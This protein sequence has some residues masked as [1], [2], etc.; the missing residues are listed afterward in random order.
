M[1][2]GKVEE[3]N[4]GSMADIAFLLLIFFLV[5][6]TMDTDSGLIRRLPPMPESKKQKT[7][8]V[9]KRNAL[10]VR[11]SAWNALMVNG[12]IIDVSK[13]RERA[14][15]F[16]ANPNN[17]A[18]LP[19][20]KAMDIPFFGKFDVPEGVISLKN[21]RGTRYDTYLFVQNELVAAYNELRDDLARSR[22]GSR[23]GTLTEDKQEAI[24]KIYPTRI[25][26]AEP[27]AIGQQ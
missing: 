10:D 5:T 4:A 1:R 23:F 7:E 19:V 6:T 15:E 27:E 22:F 17:L 24:R 16:I 12:D 26:E 3:I 18:T 2:K 9:N 11:V 25:S 20:K 13:L 21:D 14:K 8:K